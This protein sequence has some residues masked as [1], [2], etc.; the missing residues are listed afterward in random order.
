MSVVLY[1]AGNTRKVRG[2]PCDI[3]ICDEYSYLHNL[4]QGYFYSPEECYIEMAAATKRLAKAI[5]TERKVQIAEPD[6]A[7]K[8]AA[9]KAEQERQVL[10]EKAQGYGL[11]PHLK[12]GIPKLEIIIGNYEALQALKSKALELGLGDV[13]DL[14]YDELKELIDEAE[15]EK[16][17]AE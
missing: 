1:K 3:L 15:K 17:D 9:D 16:E 11:S 10:L 2:V 14:E 7:E 12:T 5:E 13:N 8:E 6:S 4:E